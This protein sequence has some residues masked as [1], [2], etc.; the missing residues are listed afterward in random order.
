LLFFSNIG[1][2]SE[3]INYLYEYENKKREEFE[4]FKE[5]KVTLFN[6]KY[7]DIDIEQTTRLNGSTQ[8]PFSK[9]RRRNNSTQIPIS[10]FV[11]VNGS[12][13]IQMPI[14]IRML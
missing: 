14:F 3:K 5:F 10:I 7:Q 2:L 1:F 4:Q 12:T 13:Q 11:A 8:I 6:K 9:T